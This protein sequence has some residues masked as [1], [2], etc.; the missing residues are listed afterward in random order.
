M[1]HQIEIQKLRD[2]LAKKTTELAEEKAKVKLVPL[3]SGVA[4]PDEQSLLSN[5]AKERMRIL[6]QQ[7][8]ESGGMCS[9]KVLGSLSLA[10]IG[11]LLLLIVLFRGGSS[12]QQTTTKNDLFGASTTSSFSGMSDNGVIG[13]SNIPTNFGAGAS[14]T[15][16]QAVPQAMVTPT[17]VKTIPQPVPVNPSGGYKCPG[18]ISVKHCFSAAGRHQ[19]ARIIQGC[20]NQ[21][22]YCV[23][24]KQSGAFIE[25]TR[26]GDVYPAPC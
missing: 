10:A 6:L 14:Q 5:K 22:R 23:Y 19:A 8:E 1:E 2:A 26:C 7:A 15:L 17:P 18:S 11:C 9:A 4:E 16:P 21:Q 25:R 24:S 12:V 3:V 20:K 13:E